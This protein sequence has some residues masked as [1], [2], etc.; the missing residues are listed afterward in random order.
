MSEAYA[1]RGASAFGAERKYEKDWIPK[2]LAGTD[3]LC[4]EPALF[5]S[6]VAT[7]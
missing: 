3:I 7:V 5:F 6:T 2:F 4:E 1:W